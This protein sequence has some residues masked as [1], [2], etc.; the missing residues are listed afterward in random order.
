VRKCI[1]FARVYIAAFMIVLIPN[2]VARADDGI[3]LFIGATHDK[4]ADS[5]AQVR[6]FTLL[7]DILENILNQMP[8]DVRNNARLGD[9]N[10]W[11][12]PADRKRLED[13]KFTHYLIAEPRAA[14]YGS[15]E[16]RISVLEIKWY[17]G[18]LSPDI[19]RAF[20]A[21]LRER[22]TDAKR[23]ILIPNLDERE[24]GKPRY[25]EAALKQRKGD[26]EGPDQ[27]N[28][29]GADAQ[30]LVDA[31][32]GK[33]RHVFPELRINNEYFI[34]CIEDVLSDGQLKKANYNLMFLL[35]GALEVK[36]WKPTAPLGAVQAEG[37]CQDKQF[38][39]MSNPAYRYDDANYLILGSL[40]WADPTKK[41]KVRPNITVKDRLV[42]KRKDYISIITQ[43]NAPASSIVSLE[44]LCV[45]REEWLTPPFMKKLVA[46]IRS[47]GFKTEAGRDL[48]KDWRCQ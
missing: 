3:K 47:Q 2:S 23:V 35:S 32:M 8:P 18:M 19:G 9:L 4:L 41:K 24:P 28:W 48:E 21:V 46:Y 43:G 39:Y 44:D 42:E 33:M 22:E 25:E 37:I 27:K 14:D 11:R 13:L 20:T 5:D 6:A 36:G 29:G 1:R 26:V 34:Q 15:S 45:R 17:L 40:M 12:M 16:K 10:S 7:Q 38:S 30:D 31:L